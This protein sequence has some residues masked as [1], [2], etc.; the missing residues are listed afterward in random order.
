MNKNYQISLLFNANKAY[1]RQVMEGI[2]EYL[3]ASQSRWNIFI[4]ED[5]TTDIEQFHNWRGDGVIA[6]FDNPSIVQL[7][8][9]ATIP[10]V[11]IGGSYAKQEDYPPVPYVATDNVKL[12]E[13]AFEHLKHK[14]L[15]KFAFYGIP[16]DS[17]ERWAI[18]RESAFVN[19]MEREGYYFSVFRGSATNSKTWQFDM[20][21]LSDWLQ[22]LPTPIGIIA[23]TDARAR[24]L[25]QM[26][27]DL[28]L[29][30]PDKVA[31]IGIDNEEVTRY[32][33]RVSLSSVGQ[34]TKSMGYAAAKLLD[35]M[36]NGTRW[37]PAQLPRILIPPTQVY[38]RQS[39]DYE[40]VDDPYVVHAMHFIRQ[41]ACKGIKVE[42][43]LDHV[44]V[45]R[46]NLEARFKLQRGHSIHQEIH[47]A[48][49]ERASYLLENSELPIS[50]IADVCGYPSIQHLYSVFKKAYNK[51]PK[52]YR[53]GGD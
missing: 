34:G 50:D 15:E 51:T 17:W 31:V 30:V 45:S 22:Q 1:D 20:N 12:I 33:T 10:V 16:D 40:G 46:T 37:S 11:G 35:K 44:G 52:E 41:N 5:F 13:M 36:L 21:R 6:D 43:V 23:V 49:L 29:M 38:A 39:S 3:Q 47:Q 9:Q 48:K 7:L 24:H 28:N 27:E 2:G 19:L 18:E 14:G 32:L 8:S 42:Q 26:C 4:Q 53:V 25:L